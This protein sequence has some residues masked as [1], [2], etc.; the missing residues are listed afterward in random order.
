M[1]ILPLLDEFIAFLRLERALSDNTT[2]SYRSDLTRLGG[3]LHQQ[4]IANLSSVTPDHLAAYVRALYDVGFAATSIQRNLSSIRSYFA[5]ASAEGAVGIDPTSFLESPRSSRYLPAVLAIDEIEKIFAA[6]DVRKRGGIRDR[7]M[8]ETL[9]ATGMRVSELALF[10][11][12]QLLSEEGLVRIFGKGS[13]ERIVPIGEVALD[14][15]KRY[16]DTERPL[17]ARPDSDSTLFL[18]AR[19]RGLTRM[20]IW[21][22][23]HAYTALA[24]IKKTVSPHTFRH[25]FATHLLE[26]GADLR[27][28]QEM[29]G[30]ANIVTTE[31]YTHVDREYLKEVHRSFHP[32]FKS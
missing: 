27:T 20:G 3:F 5:F 30:H 31:I 24:G 25:S 1:D 28:V 16:E 22:I 32:R 10:T 14:W 4:A 23:I 18:N 21:K 26:G 17:F 11:L 8:I 2:E 13:K 29:L 12:E 19:G 7:A 15:I 6:I 9:Y